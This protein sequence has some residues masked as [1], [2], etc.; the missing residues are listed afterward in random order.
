MARGISLIGLNHVCTIIAEESLVNNHVGTYLDVSEIFATATCGS[1]IFTHR[2][3]VTTHIEGSVNDSR[4]ILIRT[5]DE[6]GHLLSIGT[7][8]VESSSG[9]QFIL[10]TRNS[11]CCQDVIWIVIEVTP[12]WAVLQVRIVRIGIRAVTATID[13][14][15]D[16]GKD[17]HRVATIDITGDVVTA[18]DIDDMTRQHSD[19]N[20]ITARNLVRVIRRI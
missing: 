13:V 8:V 10:H 3:T 17:T 18:I 11:L 9:L 7:E 14:A 1:Y 6:D 4:M 19:T 2:G 16:M 12:F 15:I 5:P 20:S